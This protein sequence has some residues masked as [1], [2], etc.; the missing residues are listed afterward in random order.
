MAKKS[1]MIESLNALSKPYNLQV[2]VGA[3]RLDKTTGL[4]VEHTV[5]INL[6]IMGEISIVEGRSVQPTHRIVATSATGAT[7]AEAKEA[8]L[9]EALQY[10]GVI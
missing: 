2:V 1:K 3:P 9:T 5:G 4:P 10:A 6:T 7:I 8:A